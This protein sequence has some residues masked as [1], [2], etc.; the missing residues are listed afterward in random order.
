MTNYFRWTIDLLHIPDFILNI[1]R[2]Y[3]PLMRQKGSL[4]CKVQ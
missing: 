1:F 2:S 4:E 3:F